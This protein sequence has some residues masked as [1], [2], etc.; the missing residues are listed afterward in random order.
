MCRELL[1]SSAAAGCVRE[2]R[3]GSLHALLLLVALAGCSCI[4]GL[5]AEGSCSPTTL[6]LDCQLGLHDQLLAFDAEHPGPRRRR[7]PYAHVGGHPAA[8]DDASMTYPAPRGLAGAPVGRPRASGWPPQGRT[9]RREAAELD[10]MRCD[11]H[12]KSKTCTCE[13]I[14]SLVKR[15][16]RLTLLSTPCRK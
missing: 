14:S 8:A 2:A 12:K 16:Q 1:P 11:S 15:S 9:G 5:V 10:D 6:R 4:C 3:G 7:A 13:S